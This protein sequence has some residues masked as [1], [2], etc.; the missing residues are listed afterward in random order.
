MA[1]LWY[2]WMASPRDMQ[3]KVAGDSGLNRASRGPCTQK[4]PDPEDVQATAG[5][6]QQAGALEHHLWGMATLSRSHCQPGHCVPELRAS[7]HFVFKL[8]VWGPHACWGLQALCKA[9]DQGVSAWALGSKSPSWV[10]LPVASVHLR[11]TLT[12]HV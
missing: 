7:L 5:P 12:S 4:E 11:D 2:R 8:E 1:Q 3:A 10:E 6:G 9:C